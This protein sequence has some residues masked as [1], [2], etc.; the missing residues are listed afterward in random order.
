MQKYSLPPLSSHTPGNVPAL[1]LSG[2]TGEHHLNFSPEA[3]TGLTEAMV[4]GGVAVRTRLRQLLHAITAAAVRSV[5]PGPGTC[6]RSQHVFQVY[7]RVPGPNMSSRSHHVF[8]VQARVPGPTTC[9]RSHH[10]LQV[11]P[12]VPGPTTWSRSRHVFH[13]PAR[14]PD[15]STCSRSYHVFQIPAQPLH[16]PA[17]GSS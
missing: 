6:S 11:L 12:R 14:V 1:R 4:I 2:G 8:Q 7:P 16:S 5:S 10:V 3:L 13:V 15:P 9:S 17:L